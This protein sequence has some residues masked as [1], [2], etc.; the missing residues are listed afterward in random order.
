MCEHLYHFRIVSNV[1]EFLGITFYDDAISTTPESTE[2]ARSDT[3]RLDNFLGG[4]DRGYDFHGL[5]RSI[6]KHGV[7]NIVL[8][9]E[10]GSECLPRPM[11]SLCLKQ[12]VWRRQCVL[13][14]SKR[15]PVRYVPFN[16]FAKL[17][18]LENFEEKGDEFQRCVRKF[19][20]QVVPN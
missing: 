20:A 13:L 1:G 19:G 4:E 15:R 9:P 7:K 10:S 2:A 11:V 16:R 5:E 8:F 18:S 6:R 12:E 3:E 14:M 17:F